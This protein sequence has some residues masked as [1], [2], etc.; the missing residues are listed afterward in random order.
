MADES[1]T[2]SL[3][4]LIGFLGKLA[5]IFPLMKLFGLFSY[6]MRFL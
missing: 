3:E 6:Y 5:Y 4:L 1:H 2:K